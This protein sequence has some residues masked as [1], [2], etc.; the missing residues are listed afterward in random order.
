MY[1]RFGKF[2][3]DMRYMN[4]HTRVR[5]IQTKKLNKYVDTNLLWWMVSRI[6]NLHNKH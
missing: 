6:S 5:R 2:K 1:L 4:F 3:F